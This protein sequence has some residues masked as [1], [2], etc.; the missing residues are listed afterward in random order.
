[1]IR[2]PVG[3]P[4]HHPLSPTFESRPAIARSRTPN[5][6]ASEAITV[7]RNSCQAARR[8]RALEEEYATQGEIPDE[9]DT[10]L[11]VLEAAVEKI[12]TRP[13]IFDQTKIGRAGAFVTL[14][15]YG[16]LAVYRGYDHLTSNESVEDGIIAIEYT[17]IAGGRRFG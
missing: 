4:D 3:Q 7:R 9:I 15:R 10:R 11:G 6:D 2:G 8:V 5:F 14:D 16:A 12:K 13:L 17:F 1:M